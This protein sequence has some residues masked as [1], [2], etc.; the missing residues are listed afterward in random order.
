MY[1]AMATQHTSQ[2]TSQPVKSRPKTCHICGHGVPG[3]MM[4]LHQNKCIRRN[5]SCNSLGGSPSNL[6]TMDGSSSPRTYST[7]SNNNNNNNTIRVGAGFKNAA[8]SSIVKRSLSD[9]PMPVAIYNSNQSV[10]TPRT[11]STGQPKQPHKR[12]PLPSP[13]NR[14]AAAAELFSVLNTSIQTSIPVSTTSIRFQR[15]EFG[16]VQRPPGNPLVQAQGKEYV[17]GNSFK[18]TSLPL[19]SK[20]GGR[21]AAATAAVPPSQRNVQDYVDYSDPGAKYPVHTPPPMNGYAGSAGSRG[22]GEKPRAS[23]ESSRYQKQEGPNQSVRNKNQI[24]EEESDR[25]EE[26]D[27]E[28]EEEEDGGGERE[29]GLKKESGGYIGEIDENDE[30]GGLTEERMPCP[31]CK[32]KFAGEERLEK[33]VTACS[34]QKTRKVFDATKARVKGTELEQYVLKKAVEGSGARKGKDQEKPI[35]A[36]KQNWRVKHDN[37]IRMVRA[38][39]QTDENGVKAPIPP[40]EPDPDYVQ[41]DHCGRRFNETAAERHIPIC[42]NTKNRPRPAAAKAGSL[43]AIV[44]E[45]EARMRK[46]LD[47]KPPAPKVKKSPEKK[48]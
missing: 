9:I 44:A 3:Q 4:A 41:C 34:K 21:V 40:S 5:I 38:N 23:Y 42:A 7:P 33:H 11:A 48:R 18:A 37:F 36:K 45:D 19:A 32:R 46:R 29:R 28:E 10:N 27:E 26:E 20:N 25:E 12:I 31:L 1:T 13:S 22:A 15:P 39:R 24:Q 16:N 8:P 35:K 2:F 17:S 47:F 14:V 30:M 43:G 6:V